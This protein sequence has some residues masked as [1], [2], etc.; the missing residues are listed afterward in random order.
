M[1]WE[2][3]GIWSNSYTTRDT[4]MVSNTTLELICL[5]N[6]ESKGTK[7][8]SFKLWVGLM[9]IAT[10][11]KTSEITVMFWAMLTTSGTAGG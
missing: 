10:Y 11:L 5:W 4:Q 3:V 7:T 2:K 1:S 8:I 9:F 6:G